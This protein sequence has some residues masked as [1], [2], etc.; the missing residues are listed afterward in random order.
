VEDVDFADPQGPKISL[1]V[2]NAQKSI[3]DFFVAFTLKEGHGPNF[4]LPVGE[5]YSEVPSGRFD[6]YAPLAFMPLLVS[7]E[8]R[9]RA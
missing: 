8:E 7:V 5:L 3:V 2:K 4:F 9:K 1:V 6:A